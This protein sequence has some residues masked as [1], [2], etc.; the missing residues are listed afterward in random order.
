MKLLVGA[1]IARSLIILAGLLLA[2]LLSEVDASSDTTRSSTRSAASLPTSSRLSIGI[3]HGG[4]GAT[5]PASLTAIPSLFADD[6]QM[7]D[8][9][10]AC[11]A[12]TEGLRRLR[13]RQM[14]HASSSANNSRAVAQRQ[15]ARDSA[16]V[17]QALGMSLNDYNAIGARLVQGKDDALKEKVG[18]RGLSLRSIDFAVFVVDGTLSVLYE[19]LDTNQSCDLMKPNLLGSIHPLL[20]GRTNTIRLSNRRVCTEPPPQ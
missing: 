20:S 13:D 12:A 3:P 1:R 7:Y 17:V 18:G 6:E 16:R 8:T 14:A 10:A 5:P 9:Y 15:Y 4:G 2:I 11:L 19:E